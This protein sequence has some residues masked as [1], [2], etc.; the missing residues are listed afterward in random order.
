[1]GNDSCLHS[2]ESCCDIET[3]GDLQAVPFRLP[4][5]FDQSNGCQPVI[6]LE[7]LGSQVMA[8]L[9]TG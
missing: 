4:T 7:V 6:D 5:I 8:I 3:V 2:G 1:M 9:G